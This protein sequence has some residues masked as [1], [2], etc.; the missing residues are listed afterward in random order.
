MMSAVSTRRS[1]LAL[2]LAV[3]LGAV[4]ALSATIGHAASRTGGVGHGPISRPARASDTR[5][6]AET[7]RERTATQLAKRRA[8]ALTPAQQ[9]GQLIIAT[10]PGAHPPVSLLAA[11][12]AG[13][14]GSVILLGDNTADSVSVTAAAAASLQ[15]AAR[16]GH[17]PGLLIMT[18]QEGGEVARLPPPPARAAAQMANP[19]VAEAQGAATARMLRRAGV[20]VDLAPVAD[21]S[22]TDGFMTQ[23]HRTFGSSP[24]GVADAACAFATGLAKGGVAY[25]L[26]HFPGLGDALDN[27]D[28]QPVSITESAAEIHADDAAYQ[29]CGDGPLTLVM[30]SSASYQN[31]TGRTPAVLSP[32]TYRQLLPANAIQAVTI[33]D[34]FQSG[35][36][37]AWSTPALR[38]IRAGLDMVLYPDDEAGALSTY[39]NLLHDVE[40]HALSIPRIEAADTAVLA[41]K[42]SLGL[43]G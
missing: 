14:V 7:A 22:R 40:D 38:A 24:S 33:S 19:R 9:V 23:E 28:D 36:I 35:A 5:V 32:V 11:I 18:D 26:K 25:T 8:A 43:D 39:A 15:R 29:R 21:V 6:I 4:I 41:L 12:T 30:I 13:H 2:G 31:V 17:D 16:A 1:G 20:N 3:V 42:A 10:Y 37:R 34:S 27:T